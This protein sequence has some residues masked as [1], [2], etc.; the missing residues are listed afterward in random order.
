MKDSADKMIELKRAI[1][2][3]DAATAKSVQLI[4]ERNELIR[5]QKLRIEQLEQEV[6]QLS[7]KNSARFF[8]N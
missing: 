5:T 7:K 6:E 1:F 4:V 3:V 8:I 2:D